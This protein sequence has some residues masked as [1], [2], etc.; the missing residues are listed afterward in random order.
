LTPLRPPICFGASISGAPTRGEM[1]NR[2]IASNLMGNSCAVA[3]PTSLFPIL[4]FDAARRI[5]QKQN[6]PRR[7]SRRGEGDELT[8]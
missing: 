1:K 6:N 4:R 8:Q 2:K 7:I 3:H 5:M